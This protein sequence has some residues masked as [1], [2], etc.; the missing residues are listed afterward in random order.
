MQQSRLN[1]KI[2]TVDGI[3]ANTLFSETP[4]NK[5]TITLTLGT[6]KF[7]FRDEDGDRWSYSRK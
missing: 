6:N 5:D 1:G 7:S 3:I 4:G 2:L